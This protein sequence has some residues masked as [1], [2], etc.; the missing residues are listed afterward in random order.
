MTQI[1][2][3]LRILILVG[4]L[5]FSGALMTATAQSELP[6]SSTPRSESGVVVSKEPVVFLKDKAQLVSTNKIK[7]ARRKYKL[8]RRVRPCCFGMV[9]TY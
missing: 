2:K 1:M 5:V 3:A 6:G 8:R 9:Y 7:K 4:I